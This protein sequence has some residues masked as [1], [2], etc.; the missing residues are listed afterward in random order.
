[1]FDIDLFLNTILDRERLIVILSAASRFLRTTNIS[2]LEK[3]D[4]R[5]SII[6]DAM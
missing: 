4:N 6:S 3:S 1:M 2:K 5:I